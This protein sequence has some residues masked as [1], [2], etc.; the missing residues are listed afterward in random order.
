MRW[1]HPHSRNTIAVIEPADS[2]ESPKPPPN[3]AFGF[4]REMKAQVQEADGVWE[5]MG[6]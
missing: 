1:R 5:G 3:A 2:V 4:G 6:L